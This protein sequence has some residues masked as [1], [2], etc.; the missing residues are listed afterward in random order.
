MKCKEIHDI[1]CDFCESRGYGTLRKGDKK[2]FIHSTGHGIGLD[3]HEAPLVGENEYELK[4]GNVI[5]IEPGL[6]DPEVG[7]VRLEDI[8]VVRR[9]GCEN[10]T[11][12]EKRL[13]L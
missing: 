3:L 9:N 2:G 11:K 6:Y 7:G 10:I 5:T 13:I 12:F 8:V 1:V 4:R